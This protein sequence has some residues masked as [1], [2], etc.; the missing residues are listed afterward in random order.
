MVK[1]LGLPQ[2]NQKTLS[3]LSS[4]RGVPMNEFAVSGWGWDW[5]E[6]SYGYEGLWSWSEL[7][8]SMLG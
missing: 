4:G 8:S 2:N 6:G 7:E 1:P 5:E 3:G